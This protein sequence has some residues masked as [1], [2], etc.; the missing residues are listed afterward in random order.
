MNHS[1]ASPVTAF[2]RLLGYAGLT[3]GLMP[4]QLLALT[5]KPSL[6]ARLPVYYHWLCCH[7]LGIEVLCRGQRSSNRPTLFV[8]NHA[9]YLDIMV[10]GS[11]VQGSF[12]AKAEVADWPFFG[13]LARLQRS[14][15]IERRRTAI[16][17]QLSALRKRLERGDSLILFPEGTSSEGIRVLPFRS[18]L[19]SALE[20]ESGAN[21][22]PVQPVSIAYTRLDDMPLERYLRPFFAWYGDMELAGHIWQSIGMGR[23]SVVVEFHPP[24]SLAECGSR[25]ALSHCCHTKIERGLRT[26]LL[27]SSP[28]V[29]ETLSDGPFPAPSARRS[30]AVSAS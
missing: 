30:R 11:L 8:A 14:V 3:L 7:I 12:V 13:W 17:D 26:A 28:Q 27:Q 21:R 22:L 2:G 5:F 29:S 15:F 1:L 16:A 4:V 19:F 23:L 9:S 24:T 6:S 10:L 18:G 20:D 25:K